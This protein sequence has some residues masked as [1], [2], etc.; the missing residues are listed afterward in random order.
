MN[1]LTTAHGAARA[2]ASHRTRRSLGALAGATL[3]VAL[4]GTQVALAGGAHHPPAAP[5]KTS[6]STTAIN[7][8]YG[9]RIQVLTKI[10]KVTKVTPPARVFKPPRMQHKPP[11]AEFKPPRMQGGTLPFTGSQ[12]SIFMIVGFALLFGGGILRI[13]GRRTARF[14]AEGEGTQTEA[15]LDP[16]ELRRRLAIEAARLGG[17]TGGRDT[18]PV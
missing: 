17:L 7:F 3:L 15:D 12:L 4:T 1:L 16:F 9:N 2:F 10:V 8:G 13:T 5:D 18:R 14:A 6:V 11:P